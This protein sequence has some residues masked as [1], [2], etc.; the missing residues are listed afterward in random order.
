MIRLEQTVISKW[1]YLSMETRY[2]D[3]K[4]DFAFKKLFQK[5]RNQELLIALINAVVGKQFH[6]P[7]V[8]VTLLDRNLD[9]EIR[10][11]KESYIDVLCEDQDGC[12]YVVEMQVAEEKGFEK[13]AQYYAY[14]TFVGQ[15]NKGEAYEGLKKVI[16]ISFMN[17]IQF[18]DIP[19]YKTEHITLEKESGK[20]KLDMVSFT[21]VELPKFEQQRPRDIDQFTQEEA[22]YYLLLHANTSTPD[23]IRKLMGKDYIIKRVFEE[24]NRASFTEDELIEY[25]AYQKYILDSQVREDRIKLEGRAEGRAE[26][27]EEGAK[28][29]K[30]DIATAMLAD[31]ASVDKVKLYTGLT[32]EEINTLA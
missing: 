19:R 21:F 12:K 32:D 3:P 15:M 2:I 29:E 22:F 17:F 13:R 24:L 1:L 28:S 30:I 23:I 26:G 6:Q 20:N 18:P 27:R 25:E 9:P 8:H 4:S 14:K 5:E 10:T 11:K 7:V 16:F 31:G